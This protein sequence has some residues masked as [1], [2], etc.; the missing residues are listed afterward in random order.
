MKHYVC[1]QADLL[2]KKKIRV[3]INDRAILLVVHDGR[4]YAILDK[5]PH[6]GAPL[7]PGKYEDGIIQCKEH[8][9]MIDITKAKVV[10][11]AKANMLV[12]DISAHDL[13]KYVAVIE[14]DKVFIVI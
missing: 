1:S 9:L 6:K 12:P 13:K 2:E 4:P 3:L 10:P 8:G 7:S 11:S 14:N 5:C